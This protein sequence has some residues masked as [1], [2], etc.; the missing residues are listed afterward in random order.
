MGVSRGGKLEASSEPRWDSCVCKVS[1]Q[2]LLH[3]RNNV[4]AKSQLGLG[5]STLAIAG[6]S[7]ASQTKEMEK[8]PLV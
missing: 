3:P 2:S 1:N 5:P 4:C 7:E 8:G 6:L